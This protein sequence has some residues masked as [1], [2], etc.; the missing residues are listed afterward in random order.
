MHSKLF[1][2]RDVKPDNFLIGLGKRQHIIYMI[3]Y[4]LAKRYKDPR[5]GLHI[6]Y[7][8]DKSLTG[9]ARYA[10]LNTHLGIEQSRRDDLESIGNVLAY[11]LRGILPWQ[12]L[13]AKNR[14]EKYALIR[15]KK[16][17]TTTEE[18]CL[19]FPKEF[20]TYLEYCKNLG[21]EEDPNYSYMRKLF[22]DLY[23]SKGFKFD[24]IFDWTKVPKAPPSFTKVELTD[25]LRKNIKT[26][27]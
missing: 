6:P 23:I 8:D 5:T 3:D 15:E 14:R 4:G 19:G 22:K 9:T 21:F 16:I 24:N 17:S 1:I 2:H 12:G 11:F 7:R 26:I 27:S 13:Q 10:S 18:L 25:P 20:I